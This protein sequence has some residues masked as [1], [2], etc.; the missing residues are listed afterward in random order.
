VAV[1]K[2]L[3]YFVHNFVY[4]LFII[5]SFSKTSCVPMLLS[6]VTASLSVP[7]STGVFDTVNGFVA[8]NHFNGSINNASANAR[9][10]NG[11]S[12]LSFGVLP[13]CP[14]GSVSFWFKPKTTFDTSIV[15]SH[16]KSLYDD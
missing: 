2:P 6:V 12:F 5:L 8:V 4:I 13:A 1:Q 3:K 14:A 10:V 9:Y 16:H 15:S 7:T 11:S